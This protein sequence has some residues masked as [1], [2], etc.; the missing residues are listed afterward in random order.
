MIML[1]LST[2]HPATPWYAKLFIY[3]I[4]AYALS[5][6]DLIPDFIPVIGLLDDLLLLPFGIWLA[7][8]MIPDHV[9]KECMQ[10]AKDYN[11]K[12]KKNFAFAVFI[13]VCWLIFAVFLLRRFFL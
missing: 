3:L 6:I 9:K 7:L 5:P 13:I 10:A 12:K 11:W 1:H 2:K 4:L 8:K